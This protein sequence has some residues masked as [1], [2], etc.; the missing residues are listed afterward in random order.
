MNNIDMEK[1][2]A[3]HGFTK[4]DIAALRQHL[5]KGGATYSVLLEELRKRFLVST[6]L[7]TIIAAGFVW[8]VAYEDRESIISYAITLVIVFLVFYVFTP[9]RLGFKAFRFIRKN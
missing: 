3:K 9:L 7:L 6:V 5:E 8:T 2:L 1:K 4:K